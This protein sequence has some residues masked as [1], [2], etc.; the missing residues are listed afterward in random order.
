MVSSVCSVVLTSLGK[1]RMT[2]VSFVET[3]VSYD[4][5]S[6]TINVTPV[7]SIKNHTRFADETYNVCQLGHDLGSTITGTD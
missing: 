2:P 3:K 5:L 6:V 4:I 1:P 7:S